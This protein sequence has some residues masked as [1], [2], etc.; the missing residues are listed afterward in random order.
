MSQKHPPRLHGKAAKKRRVKNAALKV[1]K[2]ARRVELRKA[3]E[4]QKK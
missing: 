3:L 4:S 2:K 1:A